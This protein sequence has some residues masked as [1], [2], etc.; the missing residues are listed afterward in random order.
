MHIFSFILGNAWFTDEIL[1]GQARYMW[2]S[3]SNEARAEYGEDYFEQAVRSLETY[4]KG[5]VS[6]CN[7]LSKTTNTCS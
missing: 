6:S 5:E 7:C 3:M 2:K 1:L 4:T